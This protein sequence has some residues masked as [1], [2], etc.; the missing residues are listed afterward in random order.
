MSKISKLSR[1]YVV[2]TTHTLK[3]HAHVIILHYH[4]ILSVYK[5]RENAINHTLH[6]DTGVKRLL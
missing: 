2:I 5:R 4:I 3:D 1:A 6:L